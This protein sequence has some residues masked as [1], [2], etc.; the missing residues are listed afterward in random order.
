MLQPVI[1]NCHI[2]AHRFTINPLLLL[3]VKRA[4][5][6]YYAHHRKSPPISSSDFSWIICKVAGDR[7]DAHYDLLV[8]HR[9]TFLPYCRRSM[10]T[11]TVGLTTASTQRHTCR[12][13]AGPSDVGR[14][15]NSFN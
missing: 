14:G 12:L 8:T 13:E 6:F 2:V 15:S 9:Q 7:R 1:L 11:D 5:I 4:P 3:T 10:G